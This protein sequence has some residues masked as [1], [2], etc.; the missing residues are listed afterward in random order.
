M[1]IANTRASQL[2]HS[3]SFWTPTATATTTDAYPTPT[4]DPR[5]KVQIITLVWTRRSSPPFYLDV[6]LLC[7]FSGFYCAVIIIVRQGW[8]VIVHWSLHLV[9]HW[10]WRIFFTSGSNA[11]F[12]QTSRCPIHGCSLGREHPCGQCQLAVS[13][14]LSGKLFP[15][16]SS[17]RWVGLLMIEEGNG[18]CLTYVLWLWSRKSVTTMGCV[19]WA[20][21]HISSCWSA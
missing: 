19:F 1:S 4:T 18:G 10:F 2:V 15:M 11:V 14:T 6:V 5:A 7:P 13:T 16:L 3:L 21:R 20:H 12:S 8:M 17:R 9:S